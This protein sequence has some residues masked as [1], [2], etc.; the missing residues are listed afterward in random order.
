MDIWQR[1]AI[2][3]REID[4]RE[5]KRIIHQLDIAEAINVAYIGSQPGQ[6]GKTNKGAKDYQRWRRK[7]YH[8]LMPNREV[9]TIWDNIKRSGRI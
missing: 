2:Y 4:L 6:K 8:E 7:K 1:R 5:K 9:V 3:N